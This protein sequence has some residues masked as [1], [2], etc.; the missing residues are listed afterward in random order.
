MNDDAIH[1][2]LEL[3][4]SY[5]RFDRYLAWAGGDRERAIS[6]YTL[7]TQISEALYTP[8]Q[9]LEITLRNQIHTVMTDAYG[10]MWICKKKLLLEKHQTEQLE[11]AIQYIKK[12]KKDVCAGKIVS[13]LSFGFWTAMLGSKYEDLWQKKLNKIAQRENG[14]GLRRKDLSSPMTPIRNLRN[15]IAHHEPILEWN[16]QKHYRNIIKITGWL[17][18]PAASWCKNYSRFSDV[19]PENEIKLL[20]K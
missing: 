5:E 3:A 16:L 1:K 11:K 13:E 7:N 4:L 12:Q 2:G 20:T 14:K 8:M 19:Y 10:E 15:R 6:L 9:M 17:S 18:Q